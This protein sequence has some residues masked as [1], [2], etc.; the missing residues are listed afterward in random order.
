LPVL[1]V[2]VPATPV[3]A[4]FPP[5]AGGE[6]AAPGLSVE[7]IYSMIRAHRKLSVVIF[8]AVVIPMALVVKFL[9]PKTYSATATLMV[10]SEIS[11]PLASKDINDALLA[12][13]MSTRVQLMQSSEVLMPVIERLKLT[14]DPE[15]IEGFSGDPSALTNYVRDGL[16]DRLEILQGAYGSQLLNV[17]ASARDPAKAARIANTVSEVY[18]EQE[19][20]RQT[21]PATERATRY[22][23]ELAELKEKVNAAQEQ[24]TAFR[25]R[26]GVTT[27]IATQNDVEAGLL[28]TMEQRYQDAQNQRRAAEVKAAGDQSANSGFISSNMVNEL[29]IKVANLESQLAE[30][31]STLGPQH[32][33]VVQLKSEL[34]ATRQSLNEE[35]RTYSNS[36]NVDL[37][38][39]RQ[40]EAK[41]KD[42]VEEQRLK[43]LNVRRLQD[44]GTKYVLELESAQSVYKRALDG[45]DEIM[46]AS[47]GHTT[48]VTF[49]SRA[50]PPLKA[51]K[52]NKPKLMIV[53]VLIGL[54]LGLTGPMAYELLF[55]RRVRCS[56]DLERSFDIPVLVELH[57]IPSLTGAA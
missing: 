4:E 5:A 19:L 7:Q 48:N 28:T 26:T 47:G 52:P 39:A 12:N 44:E 31:S 33:K 14:Q 35:L 40:L 57:S 22:S 23:Q 10:N 53:S 18:S 43:V 30:L 3:E 56:D 2:A 21:G 50:T 54:M 46:F 32:P 15:F 20:H 37:V 51:S 24:V 45:Y 42:A 49:V 34:A 41:L 36:A 8:L 25:Q 13:Y 6:S 27:D 38:A 11:N 55:D 9:M 16:S 1:S 29:K 17:T